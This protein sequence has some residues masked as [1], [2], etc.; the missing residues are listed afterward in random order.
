MS[1]AAP[2]IEHHRVHGVLRLATINVDQTVNLPSDQLQFQETK[3][4]RVGSLVGGGFER[5][6]D[7]RDLVVTQRRIGTL[8]DV[9]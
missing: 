7:E 4:G 8:K 6:T 2:A 1:K 9:Q 3:A 5:F